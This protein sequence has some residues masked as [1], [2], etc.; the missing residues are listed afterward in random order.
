MLDLPAKGELRT[1][2]RLE[3]AAS[4]EVLNLGR[5]RAVTIGAVVSAVASMAAA[6][7]PWVRKRISHQRWNPA[8]TL[9]IGRGKAF[10]LVEREEQS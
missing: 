6:W 1:L 9:G 4:W 7:H 3:E 2:V 8:G 10:Y 5:K